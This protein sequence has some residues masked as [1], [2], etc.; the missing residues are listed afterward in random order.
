ML[1]SDID[2]AAA[3]H[4][5]LKHRWD[6][7][8][9]VSY[10]L[11]ALVGVVTVAACVPLFSVLI[12]LIWRGGQRLSWEVF[13]ETPPAALSEGG[14]FGNAILGTI[15]MVGLAALISV[16]AGIL[17]AVYLSE[18]GRNSRT[19]TVVRFCAKVLSGFPSVLAGGFVYISV[20]LALGTSSAMAGGIALSILMLP[21]V[22]LTAEEAM[23]MVPLK[24]K[25]AAVGM[26]ATPTQVTWKIVLP[27]SLPSVLTGVM[28][29]IARAAGE[30]AP[31][32]FTA[33]FSNYWLFEDQ[34]KLNEPTASLAV[35]IYNFYSVPFDNQIELAWAA[36]L[37]LVSMVLVT[38]IGGQWLSR[39]RLK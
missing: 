32:L 13:V 37:V 16:P 25:E 24:M 22:M 36:A 8:T 30:T 23:R 12:M 4:G 39:R 15:V 5:E 27:T 31:L 1:D 35:L 26:G 20:V 14:G 34:W 3:M 6:R 18:F 28:L 29:A 9:F 21:I 33:Q 7:R 2:T 11:S 19:A 38:N 10:V 17:C